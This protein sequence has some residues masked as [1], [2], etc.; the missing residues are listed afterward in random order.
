MTFPHRLTETRLMMHHSLFREEEGGRGEKIW[1]L[2]ALKSYLTFLSS[3]L[4]FCFFV[5]FFFK[6]KK[7]I[8]RVAAPFAVKHPKPGVYPNFACN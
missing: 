4:F 6:K 5:L 2:L 1:A 3:F 7:L 8:S